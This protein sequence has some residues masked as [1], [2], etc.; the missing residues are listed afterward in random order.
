MKCAIM[1][2]DGTS[3]PSSVAY[4]ITARQNGIIQV[5]VSKDFLKPHIQKALYE[6]RAA[7]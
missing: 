6:Q 7:R 3:L 4:L 2:N 5:S 1:I